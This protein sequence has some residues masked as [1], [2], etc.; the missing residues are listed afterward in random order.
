M[1]QKGCP[2]LKV[3]GKKAPDPAPSIS[4]RMKPGMISTCKMLDIRYGSNFQNAG[5]GLKD[6]AGDTGAV[7]ADEVFYT[8][9]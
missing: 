1:G 8:K 4:D 5:C 2:V 7:L 3:K 6:C 9:M